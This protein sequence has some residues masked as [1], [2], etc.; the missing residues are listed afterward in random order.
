MLMN[1]PSKFKL[2][3]F[4]LYL[5]ILKVDNDCFGIHYEIREVYEEN[6]IL[7]TIQCFYCFD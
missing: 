6:H 5:L 4:D 7:A 2:L 3:S 1:Y